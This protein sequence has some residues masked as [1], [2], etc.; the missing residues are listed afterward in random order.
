MVR[1]IDAKYVSDYKV[2]V[3]FDDGV[4][5]VI[6]LEDELYGEVFEPLRDVEKFKRFQLNTDIHTI[7][8][9]TGADFAPEFLHECAR[10]SACA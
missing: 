3:R 2:W 1:V 4:E 5:G 9:E 8:W 10:L 7:T 6:N